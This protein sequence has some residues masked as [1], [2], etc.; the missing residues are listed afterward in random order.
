[1]QGVR[2]PFHVQTSRGDPKFDEV[3]DIQKLVFN[4]PVASVAFGPPV[5]KAEHRLPAGVPRSK[6]PSRR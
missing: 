3:V 1:V 4:E 5:A 2:I 6:C